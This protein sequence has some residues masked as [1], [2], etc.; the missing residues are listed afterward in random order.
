MVWP[1]IVAGLAAV[2]STAAAAMGSDGGS[3]AHQK[4]LERHA[5]EWRDFVP[6][7]QAMR[8]RAL[9]Q[10]LS[11]FEPGQAEMSRL[12]GSKAPQFDMPTLKEPIFQE[13][14]IPE[15]V[16]TPPPATV[17]RDIKDVYDWQKE[18]TLPKVQRTNPYAPL[19]S[20]FSGLTGADRA[21]AEERPNPWTPSPMEVYEHGGFRPGYVPPPLPNELAEVMGYYVPEQGFGPQEGEV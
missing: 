10:T 14:A 2:G 8:Q 20:S 5:K 13:S 12:F 3:G 7:D 6:K 4:N 9:N 15:T 19:L 18:I 17:S 11:L 16:P 21:W 1:A